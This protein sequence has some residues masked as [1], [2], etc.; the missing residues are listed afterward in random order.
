MAKLYY[1]YGAM[2]SAKTANLLMVAYNYEKLGG[3]V[4]LLKP[5]VDD[6]FGTGVLV[7]R[8]G[9]EQPCTELAH[10]SDTYELV[11]KE[12]ESSKLKCILVD[13]S[14]FLSEAQILGF[15]RI[16]DELNIPV[17]CYGLKNSY[18]PGKLFEGSTALLYYSDSIEEIKNVCVFCDRKAT[19]N[20]R[21]VNGKPVY[22]G[23]IVEVGDTKAEASEHYHPTCRRHYINPPT[24]V[25][26]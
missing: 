17:I 13:E 18:Q 9:I 3:R 11:K 12:H 14:Q 5:A 20:L 2:D 26:L 22:S 6:R 25:K 16:V 24:D 4:L 23:N 7:S 15:V 19:M 8:L 10:D 1:R 21:I